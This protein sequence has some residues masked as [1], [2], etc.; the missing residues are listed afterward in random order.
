MT[1]DRQSVP[2]LTMTSR[3]LAAVMR[4]RYRKE[5]A[6]QDYL[7]NQQEL[8]RDKPVIPPFLGDLDPGD[9]VTEN[10]PIRRADCSNL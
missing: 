10:Q 9:H 1:G 2:S 8:G 7:N 5:P 4:Q 6:A 3:E